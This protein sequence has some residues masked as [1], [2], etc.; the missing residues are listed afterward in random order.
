MGLIIKGIKYTCMG[1]GAYVLI[2]GCIVPGANMVYRNSDTAVH[3]EHTEALDRLKELT[4][5][6][7][8]HSNTYD[9]REK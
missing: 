7:S 9:V 5:Y 6:D 8:R 3:R 4:G 1:V 2:K